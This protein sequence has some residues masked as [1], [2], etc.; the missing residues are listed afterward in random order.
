MPHKVL[1]ITRTFLLGFGRGYF[2]LRLKSSFGW[3]FLAKLTQGE[4]WL[5]EAFL[6]LMRII[7]HYVCFVR[8]P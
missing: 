1:Q 2:L 4:F 3:L 6:I 8:K 7:I 5:K